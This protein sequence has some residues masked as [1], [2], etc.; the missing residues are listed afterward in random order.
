AQR[1]L[2]AAEKAYSSAQ[3]EE[4]LLCEKKQLLLHKLETLNS[5]NDR[6]HQLFTQNQESEIELENCTSKRQAE[7]SSECNHLNGEFLKLQNPIFTEL[8]IRD[9]MEFDVPEVD[10]ERLQAKWSVQKQNT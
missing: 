1:E 9:T 6:L 5:M 2:S 8:S 4:L 3:S 7:V 10:I